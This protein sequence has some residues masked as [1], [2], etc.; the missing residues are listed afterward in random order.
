MARNVAKD[1]ETAR[2]TVT[3]G[4]ELRYSEMEKI[5]LLAEEGCSRPNDV[6]WNII[7]YAFYVGFMAGLRQGGRK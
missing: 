3:R 4:R 1:I 5:R 7:T 2:S 6:I